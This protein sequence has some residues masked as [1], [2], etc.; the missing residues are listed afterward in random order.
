M[1]V[2]ILK[3]ESKELI[4]EFEEKDTTIPELIAGR[5][6]EEDDVKFAAVAQDHPEAGKPRLILKTEK[7]KA[8]DTLSKVIE[9]LE[10]DFS[11]IKAHISK[12]K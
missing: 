3:N 4:V 5:L 7:K 10:D 9:G 11:D 2:S 6:N 12:K 8:A 1:K